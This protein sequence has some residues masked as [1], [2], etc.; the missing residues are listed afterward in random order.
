M[1]QSISTP[2]P[3]LLTIPTF[4]RVVKHSLRLWM[5]HHAREPTVLSRVSMPPIPLIVDRFHQPCLLPWRTPVVELKATGQGQVRAVISVPRGDHVPIP[6]AA[7]SSSMRLT[8]GFLCR[9][10]GNTAGRHFAMRRHAQTRCLHARR[11]G[12]LAGPPPP[13]HVIPWGPVPTIFLSMV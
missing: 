4:D 8:G 13:V 5:C 6:Q 10:D 1:T 2:E 12:T 9:L 3:S 7:G 11:F